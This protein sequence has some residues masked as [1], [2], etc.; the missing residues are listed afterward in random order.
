MGKRKK[1]FDVIGIIAFI[2]VT[3]LWLLIVVR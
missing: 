1:G 2:V 3:I